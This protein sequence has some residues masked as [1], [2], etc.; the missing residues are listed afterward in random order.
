MASSQSSSPQYLQKM[1][2]A[3][4]PSLEHDWQLRVVTDF[5]LTVRNSAE[6]NPVGTM[7]SYQHGILNSCARR[8]RKRRHLQRAAPQSHHLSNVATAVCKFSNLQNNGASKCKADIRSTLSSLCL[9]SHIW[10]DRKINSHDP[11]VAALE[12]KRKQC[13]LREV[14]PGRCRLATSQ[15]IASP[16]RPTSCQPYNQLCSS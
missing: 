16:R 13:I 3:S 11:D 8:Y 2:S 4:C 1:A 5:F 6:T 15:G 9:A 12:R 14:V 7:I 10:R